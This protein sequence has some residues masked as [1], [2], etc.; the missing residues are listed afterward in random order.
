MLQ[1]VSGGSVGRGCFGVAWVVASGEWV[2]EGSVGTS[3]YK[4]AVIDKRNLSLKP[5]T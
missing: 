4:V 5:L 1:A 3:L 2:A